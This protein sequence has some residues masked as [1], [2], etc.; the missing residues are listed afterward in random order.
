[1]LE[2]RALS[3]DLSV[4]VWTLASIGVLF[5]TGLVD[6]LRE[7]RTLD[8]L[9]AKCPSFKK[10]RLER[11]IALAAASG[12]VV[13][14]GGRHRLAEGVMPFLAPPMRQALQGEIRTSLMQPL[15]FLD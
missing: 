1:M 3:F 6:D 4:S 9:A 13:T 8:E 5:D 15:A 11:T 7:P 10:S 14:D 2:T 12:F